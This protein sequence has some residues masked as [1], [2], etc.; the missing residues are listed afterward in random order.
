MPRDVW[1]EV[2]AVVAAAHDKQRGAAA[3]GD[4]K[5]AVAELRS[6][7]TKACRYLLIRATEEGAGEE[8]QALTKAICPT[9]GLEREVNAATESYARRPRSACTTSHGRRPI[10]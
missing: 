5:D 3:G 7:K 1:G 2:K 10:S 4:G 6:D 9:D 8:A